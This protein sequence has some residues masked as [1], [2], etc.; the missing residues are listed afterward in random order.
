[1]AEWEGLKTRH[2]PLA[3]LFARHWE[4]QLQD[5]A[6][7][8]FSCR[9]A[10]IEPRF[11][12]ALT[13][14]LRQQGRNAVECRQMVRQLQTRPLLQTSHHVTPTAGP[15][16][17]TLDLIALSGLPKKERLLIGANSGVA[18]SN[19]AWSGALSYLSSKTTD[20]LQAGALCRE[21]EKSNA[22]RLAQGVEQEQRISLIPAQSRDQLVYGEPFPPRGLEVW[23]AARPAL[24]DLL[25]KPIVGSDYAAWATLTAQG[26]QKAIF[27]AEINIFDLNPVIARYLSRLLL[28]DPHHPLCELLRQPSLELEKATGQAI[29][30]LRPYKGKKSFKVESLRWNGQAL[31]GEKSGSEAM[32]LEELSQALQSERL[33]PGVTILFMALLFQ[34]IKCLGSFNQAV[35]LA[36]LRKGLRRLDLFPCLEPLGEEITT[37][38]LFLEGRPFMPLD[39]VLQGQKL[40]LDDFSEIPM[41]RFWQYYAAKLQA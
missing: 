19:S 6:P 36:Q 12:Q 11:L 35:Y 17:L 27:Q 14:S 41:S 1:M 21:A 39:M 5:F 8:L 31:R 25:P 16:F 2:P 15:T 24:R 38:R 22:T 40:S 33:C 20:L 37:G 7:L 29:T 3:D 13:Q 28:E 34:G 30:F 32:S 18:F 26:L 4:T 9:P 10:Q 23:Q